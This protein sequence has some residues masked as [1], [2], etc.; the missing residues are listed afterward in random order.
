VPS[1]E[2]ATPVQL[3]CG[4]VEVNQLAPELVEIKMSPANSPVGSIK[5]HA[6]RTLPSAEHVMEEAIATPFVGLLHVQFVP[7]LVEISTACPLTVSAASL[8]PSAE[9]VTDTQFATGAVVCFQVCAY[10]G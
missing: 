7:P 4:A 2:Q 9:D 3:K 1:A 8:M 5:P 6:T 10:A